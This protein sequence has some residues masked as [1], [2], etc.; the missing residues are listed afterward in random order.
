MTLLSGPAIVDL[1]VDSAPESVAL[2]RAGLNGLGSQLAFE[3]ELLDDLQMAASEACN[4]V[5]MH[6]YHGEPGALDVRVTATHDGVELLVRD[7]GDGA[8]FPDD[9]EDEDEDDFEGEPKLGM[10][11]IRALAD[12]TEFEH[13]PGEGTEVRMHFAREIAAVD[14]GTIERTPTRS[15]ESAEL[16]GDIVATVSPVALLPGVL[17]RLSRTL[18]AHARFSVERFSELQRVVESVVGQT[19][20]MTS[21]GRMTFSLRS[22][23]RRLSLRIGPLRSRD[24]PRATTEVRRALGTLVD[25]VVVEALARD[26]AQAR[27]G[28]QTLDGSAVMLCL[29]ITDAGIV[30]AA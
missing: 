2:V 22:E 7:H 17:G 14:N 13:I 4:N 1:K 27:D 3:P 10:A 23:T 12:D 6:A 8:A 28:M 21:N 16:A 25:E 26:E 24:R 5:V 30:P 11:L 18:A 19:A 9:G 15:R 29:S 20:G